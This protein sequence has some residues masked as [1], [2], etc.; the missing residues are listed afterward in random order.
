MSKKLIFSRKSRREKR[1]KVIITLLISFIGIGAIL[2]VAYFGVKYSKLKGFNLK[3]L[4]G[5]KQE[6][7]LG[8]KTEENAV[9]EETKEDKAADK[10]L[11]KDVRKSS[12]T[13]IEG[14]KYT[15]NASEVQ[16]VNEKV[17]PTDGKK[18]VFLTFDD[19][20][21]LANTPK[22]LDIL[23]SNDVKATFF[24]LAKNF[25]DAPETSTLL[26]RELE[27]G[28]AIG[29]HGTSHLYEKLY[30]K[31]KAELNNIIEDFD[32]SDKQIKSILGDDFETRV[33]RFPG[34]SMSWKN[35]QPVKDYF[36]GK[37][38]AYV[39]WMVDSSDAKHAGRTKAQIISEIKKETEKY[40][41]AKIDKITILMHDA[42]GKESTVDAL[43]EIIAYFKERG[44]E[45]KTLK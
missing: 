40:E 8:N 6:V 16:K 42:A 11:P 24:I 15:Y 34:G 2:S 22:V 3:N 44:Y 1:K 32:N 41:A 25:N 31:N 17:V 29:N 20:P 30:P 19:G 37:G 39:D 14:D 10:K 5:N 26:E 45:F 38:I 23:K 33:I 27:E 13:S 28:H 18:M 9:I 12:N 21:S 7:T 4:Y 36:K 35:M 43:P